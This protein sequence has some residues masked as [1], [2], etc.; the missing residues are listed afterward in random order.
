MRK[1]LFFTV[2]ALVGVLIIGCTAEEDNSNE[3]TDVAATV[4]GIDISME[5]FEDS[6]D[7]MK[8]SYEQQGIDLEGE[9]GQQLLEQINQQA[10]NSLVQEEVLMQAVEQEGLEISEEELE[11]EFTKIKDEFETEEEFQSALEMSGFTEE[12]FKTALATDI[13]IG[14]F[15]D[16]E[17]EEVSVSEDELNEMYEQYIELL[18]S[19][20]EETEET[21]EVPTFEEIKDQLEAQIKQG[22]QQEQLQQIMEK[23]MEES[24]VE[25]F[26]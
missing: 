22:K 4:N 18:E 14:Q 16:N 6:V 23:L 12:E 11:E 25:I 2:I 26:V 17:M 20:S 7:M 24:D 19:Y 3:T 15:I 1:S 21:Q 13:E 10:I 8:S 9:E 5:R